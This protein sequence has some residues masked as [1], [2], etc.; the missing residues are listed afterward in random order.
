MKEQLWLKSLLG[1]PSPLVPRQAAS[2]RGGDLHHRS[3]ACP[4]TLEGKRRAV[5]VKTIKWK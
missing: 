3:N 2:C 1:S 4:Q 5:E